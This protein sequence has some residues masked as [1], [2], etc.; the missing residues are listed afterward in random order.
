MVG[1]GEMNMGNES[2]LCCCILC[3][4]DLTG[5]G[6]GGEAAEGGEGECSEGAPAAS[7]V[8]ASEYVCQTGVQS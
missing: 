2:D 1:E 8:P 4:S 3:W 6:E 7:P 5:A